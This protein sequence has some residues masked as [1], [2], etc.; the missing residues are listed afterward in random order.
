MVGLGARVDPDEARE[1]HH[2]QEDGP[3]DCQSVAEEPAEALTAR[4]FGNTHGFESCPDDL[5][6]QLHA[7]GTRVR[8]SSTPY[9]TSASRLKRTTNSVATAIH[10]RRTG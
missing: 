5:V 4:A 7:H 8:G 6:A 9:A 1:D 10:A 2:D 3:H